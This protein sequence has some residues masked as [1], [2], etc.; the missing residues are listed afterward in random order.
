MGK[1]PRPRGEISPS[2]WGNI[3][4]CVGNYPH[5]YGEVNN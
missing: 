3:P 4:V 5:A 1:Y 2:V